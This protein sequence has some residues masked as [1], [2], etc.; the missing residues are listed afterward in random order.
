MMLLAFIAV[1]GCGRIGYDLV[2]ENERFPI[3]ADVTSGVAAGGGSGTGSPDMD[4]NE[5][6][7]GAGGDSSSA[8][9]VARDAVGDEVSNDVPMTDA[10]DSTPAD[11]AP[12]SEAAAETGTGPL[13]VDDSVQGTGTNQFNY[14]GAGWLHC[15]S[16]IIGQTY[17]DASD[18]WSNLTNDFVTFSFVG[19]QLD[20]Y[21]VVDTLHGIGAVSVDGG[22]ETSIDF[23]GSTR[24]GNQLLWTSP[25]L[26]A[27]AHTFGLRVTGQKNRKSS[28]YFVTV[29]RVDIR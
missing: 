19:T 22:A 9:A 12:A 24:L 20:F 2:D 13:S 26:P 18:S 25:S 14:V 10:A 1:S 16:C 6:Q 3:Q 28:D 21:G 7:G 15:T 27:G 5:A 17:Y 29:D 23:Y 8:D 11:A 4:A